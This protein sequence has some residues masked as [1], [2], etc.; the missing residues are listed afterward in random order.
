MAEVL[1]AAGILDEVGSVEWLLEQFGG[2]ILVTIS[3][4][5]SSIWHKEVQTG[6][7]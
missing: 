4:T 1:T 3:G 2:K 7:E 5:V 6:V